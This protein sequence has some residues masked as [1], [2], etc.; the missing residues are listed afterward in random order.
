[1]SLSEAIMMA[2]DWGKMMNEANDLDPHL[3]ISFDMENVKV[4]DNKRDVRK[5]GYIDW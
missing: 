4:I 2:K 3:L 1:M 5:K